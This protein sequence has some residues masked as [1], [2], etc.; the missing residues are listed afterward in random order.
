VSSIKTRIEEKLKAALQSSYLEV[1]D[2]S[3]QHQGHSGAKPGGETHFRILVVSDDFA[4][5]TRISRHRK[6]YEILD[7]EIKERVHALAI[8]AFTATEFKS[9]NGETK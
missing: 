3:S 6:I 2:E 7:T 1:L 4:N 5:T 8:T 9:Y